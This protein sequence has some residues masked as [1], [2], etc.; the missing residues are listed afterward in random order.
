MSARTL[1]R[2]AFANPLSA[3]YLGVVGAVAV[4]E[5]VAAFIEGPQDMAGIYV[6]LVTSPTSLMLFSFAEAISGHAKPGLETSVV[7]IAVS[8][9]LQALALGLLW[10]LVRRERAKP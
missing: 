8:A 10:G 5:L 6:L 9:L 3:V 7:V 4:F 1:F 2:T